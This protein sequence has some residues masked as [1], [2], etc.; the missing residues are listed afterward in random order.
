MKLT[1]HH[2]FLRLGQYTLNR[3]NYAMTLIVCCATVIPASLSLH[4]A[5]PSFDV[6]DKRGSVLIFLASNRN[7]AHLRLQSYGNL[8]EQQHCFR[9]DLRIVT[10]MD[11]I[12]KE[13]EV[14]EQ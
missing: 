13:P 4:P 9:T 7:V 5:S 6:S 11:V 12:Q 1:V 14:L 2:E 8:Y 3:D 10:A